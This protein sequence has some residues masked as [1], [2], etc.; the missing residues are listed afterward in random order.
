MPPLGM[1]DGHCQCT[2]ATTTIISSSSVVVWSS[3]TAADAKSNDCGKTSQ[4]MEHW[5]LDFPDAL[6]QTRADIQTSRPVISRA[7][8]RIAVVHDVGGVHSRPLHTHILVDE[9]R[10]GRGHWVTSSFAETQLSNFSL[11]PLSET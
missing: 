10:W 7:R 5:L 11:R 3:P 1:M 9:V 4:T 8:R 6:S 2:P